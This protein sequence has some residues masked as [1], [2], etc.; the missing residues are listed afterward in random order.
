MQ[1]YIS[2]KFW[3]LCILTIHIWGT[4]CWYQLIS[5]L[6]KQFDLIFSNLA[7]VQQLH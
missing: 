6:G 4:G 1:A 5:W 3:L 2:Q 7:L